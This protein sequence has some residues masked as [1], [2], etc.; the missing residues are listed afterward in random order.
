[1]RG[2]RPAVLPDVFVGSEAVEAGLLTRRQLRSRFVVRVLQGVYRPAWV[3]LTH[4]LKCRAACLVLPA[5]AVVTGVSAAT[6]LGVRLARPDDVVTVYTPE[7]LWVSARAGVVVRKVRS[8]PS[9]ARLLDGVRLADE[10]RMAFDAAAGQSKAEATARLDAMVRGRLLNLESF[11]SWVAGNHDQHVRGVR[12]AVDLVDARAE[13]LPES[14]TR[15]R[16]REAGFDVTPQYLIRDGAVVVARVDL[17]I[18]ALR[19]AIE[20]DGRWHREEPQRELDGSRLAAIRS[21]GWTVVTVTAEMLRH[22]NQLEAAVG[23][24]VRSRTI[25]AS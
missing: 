12:A 22:P 21:L 10:R 13:S 2:S 17:A 4:T 18:P 25:L 20:Y 9:S 1:M 8:P 11:R 14:I 3:P 5:H 19:I 24:A 6:V 16:L 23:A 15:V 7:G